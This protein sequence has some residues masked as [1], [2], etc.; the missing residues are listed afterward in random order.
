MLRIEL[1]NTSSV[2]EPGTKAFVNHCYYMA[3][4]QRSAASRNR[5]LRKAEDAQYALEQAQ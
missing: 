1:P 5:W 3:E 4:I 2:P